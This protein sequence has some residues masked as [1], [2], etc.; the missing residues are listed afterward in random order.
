MLTYARDVDNGVRSVHTAILNTQE[1]NIVRFYISSV[2]CP[3][4]VL[5][6]ELGHLAREPVLIIR[7]PISLNRDT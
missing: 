7:Y 2:I 6:L 3:T 5:A 1:F 4:R